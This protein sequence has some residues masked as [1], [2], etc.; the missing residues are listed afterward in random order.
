ML[1]A[2]L[3]F[4]SYNATEASLLPT[5]LHQGAIGN[6]AP[7][8]S[9]TIM[10][11][12]QIGG[13]LASGMQNTVICSEDEPLFASSNIDRQRIAQTYQGSDQLDALAEICKVWPR[14]PVDPGL[15]SPL[16][17][18][19][20]TL[21]LSG[22]ADP[23]TPPDDALRAAQGLRHHRN[24]VLE[25]EGHGQ[26]ATGCVPTLMASFL[27]DAVPETL[28]TSCLKQHHPAPF[29]VGLS[30]PSP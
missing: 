20:P 28:D 14:G 15:H 9:Q 23:V 1:N 19:V 16:H 17:S 27:D 11:S 10:M 30:G 6:L 29:F 18:D 26:V 25:G 12:R 2:A 21:L 24:L 13:Q 5:L 22:D 8:A 3:R 7:L 4:L